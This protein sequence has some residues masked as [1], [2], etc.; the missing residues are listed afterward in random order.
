[1]DMK[2]V[3][4]A[5]NP[6]YTTAKGTVMTL[7]AGG[8]KDAIA[9][10]PY[11]ELDEMQKGRSKV[12]P[13]IGRVYAVA[14]EARYNIYNHA[15]LERKEPIIVDL[16]SGYSPRGFRTADAGKTYYG[17]DLPAVIDLMKTAVSKT[18]TDE[19]KRFVQYYSV[20]ATNY[21][22]LKKALES[23]DGEICIVTEGLMGYLSQPELVSMC[24][25]IHRLLSEKGGCW[26]TADAGILEIYILTYKI[27]VNEDSNELAAA[28]KGHASN[29]AD[30]DFY[31]NSLFLNGSD[32]A[33]AFLNEQGFS[34]KKESVSDY[35]H[36]LHTVNKDEEKQLSEKYARM[37]IWTMTVDK[38]ATKSYEAVSQDTSFEVKSEVKDGI[39]S[40]EIR[41]RVD[42]IT[43]PELLKRFQ[44]AG[45]GIKSICVDVSEMSYVSSAGLRVFLT[46]RK[47]LANKECI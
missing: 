20:D 21:D 45:E 42:T 27:L 17:L 22:S 41:G 18:M 8:D 24:Q 38:G 9:L 34:V 29:M 1:M 16:P 44:E 32:G 4:K 31:N 6:V 11:L 25:A 3:Q 26:I 35:I 7:A 40:V 12:P 36:G 14:Q 15:A 47:S 43:A 19:Q 46:M 13:E 37:E 23:T 33:I 39:F 30:V 2:E 28:M 5:V 10:C